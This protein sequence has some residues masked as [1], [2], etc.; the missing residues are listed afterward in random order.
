M[1]RLGETHERN[2]HH[3]SVLWKP[4]VII[5]KHD[6]GFVRVE[7]VGSLHR[8]TLLPNSGVIVAREQVDT[9]YPVDLIRQCL[10]IGGFAWLCDT[11]ARDE[12][13]DDILWRDISA[14]V[15]VEQFRHRRVL[16][17]GCGS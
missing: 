2:R 17:F 7:N 15:S 3:T 14:F 6:D 12:A 4:T 11:I 10:D 1:G 5:I 16:D 13:A 8:V 9:T